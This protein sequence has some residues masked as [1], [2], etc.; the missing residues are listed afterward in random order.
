MSWLGP[1]SQITAIGVAGWAPPSASSM[2]RLARSAQHR[3]VGQGS[4][5]A[6]YGRKMGGSKG[7]GDDRLMKQPVRGQTGGDGRVRGPAALFLSG[8]QRHERRPVP[9]VVIIRQ[10]VKQPFEGREHVID[11]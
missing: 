5:R 7:L 10:A 11:E 9:G 2:A 4:P 6:S 1:R 3:V 8:R